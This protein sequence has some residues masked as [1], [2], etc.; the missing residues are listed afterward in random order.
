VRL[1]YPIGQSGQ[2]LVFEP[3]TLAH[4]SEHVQRRWWHPEAGGQLFARVSGGAIRIVLATGPRP[5]DTR[6]R[7]L[8]RPDRRAEQREIDQAHAEGLRY[9]GDWHTHPQDIPRP[10]GLDRRTVRSTF[11]ESRHDMN[12]VVMA[13]VG[14]DP[15][16]AGLHVSI[17]DAA[18]IYD[19]EV[20]VFKD[21]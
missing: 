2:A 4:M 3:E 15:L 8:Y 21:D 6:W 10:S 19:L 5:T 20:N 14:R 13:I 16:P 9:I 18:G 7:F 12:G 11:M 1:R 17:T